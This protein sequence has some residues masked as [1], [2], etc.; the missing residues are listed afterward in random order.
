MEIEKDLD[1]DNAMEE[2][3]KIPS[4]TKFTDGMNLKKV[5]YVPGKILNIVVGK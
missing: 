4:V 2:A 1:Q 5:I 3:M